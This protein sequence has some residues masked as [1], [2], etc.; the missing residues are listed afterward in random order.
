MS[1]AW[2]DKYG[3]AW[4]RVFKMPEAREII[5]S[6]GAVVDEIGPTETCALHAHNGRRSFAAEL[7]RV[8][9]SKPDAQAKRPERHKGR[10]LPMEPE[11]QQKD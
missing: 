10:R 3:D 11:R 7:L 5:E 4:R 9:S 2:R 6:L 1:E 8:G